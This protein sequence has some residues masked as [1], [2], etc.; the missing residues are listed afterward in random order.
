M[1]SRRARRR[2]R[3]QPRPTS[4]PASTEPGDGTEPDQRTD[5]RTAA[6]RRPVSYDEAVALTDESTALMRRGRLRGGAPPRAS[7]PT[8]ACAAPATSTRRTP[9]TTPASR[10]SSSGTATR[11]FGSSTPR[12]RSRASG[13]RSTRRA[14]SAWATSDEATTNLAEPVGVL[15]AV[16]LAVLARLERLPPVAPLRGT[17]R[18]SSARPSSN[19]RSGSQ[20]RARSFEESSAVAPVVA[21]AVVD[22]ADERR[23]G[24]GQLEDPLRDL[25]VLALVA[26]RRRCRPRRARPRGGR[27]RPPRSGRR[28][29][30]S[31]ASAA[32]RR[33]P[34]SGSPSSA[35]VT[36]SGTSFSGYWFGP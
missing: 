5:R 28:R 22:V 14:P 36:K 8:G 9:P 29:G 25:E 31:R 3:R 21:R 35:F 34:G 10:T 26:R 12:R 4:E 17:T 33:R 15:A 24:A 19:E 7:A 16:V 6:A 11:G 13:A 23:V 32:R 27:A 20:P 1:R 18:R 30:A 2:R